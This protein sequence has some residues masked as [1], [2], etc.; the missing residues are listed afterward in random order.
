MILPSKIQDFLQLEIQ[1]QHGHSFDDEWLGVSSI[2]SLKLSQT[3]DRIT[4]GRM[5][6][7]AV[8]GRGRREAGSTTR[9]GDMKPEN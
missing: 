5:I 7:V 3:K 4:I 1:T 6:Q 2:H 8:G 9:H